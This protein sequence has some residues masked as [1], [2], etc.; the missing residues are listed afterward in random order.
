MA[1][2][3]DFDLR[4]EMFQTLME[5]VESDQYPS[6]TMLDWIEE[7]LTPEELPIYAESLLRRIREDTY[8]SIPMIARL[9][10]L[11]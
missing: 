8:P 9:K 4:A 11:A 1:D 10:R 7:L 5:K 3:E 2:R 6:T